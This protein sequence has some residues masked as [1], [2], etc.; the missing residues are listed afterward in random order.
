LDRLR[1]AFKEATSANAEE[2]VGLMNAAQLS[3]ASLNIGLPKSLNEAESREVIQR[4]LSLYPSGSDGDTA[5]SIE[6]AHFVI[7]CVHILR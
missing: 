3:V 6:F 4:V 2:D 5:L 7:I 1:M